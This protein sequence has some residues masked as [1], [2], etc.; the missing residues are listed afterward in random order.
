MSMAPSADPG[1]QFLRHS[2]ATVAY[3]GGKVLRGAP[4][5]FA[6]FQSANNARTPAK[7]LA[8]M[9][10]LFDWAHSIVSGQAA[11]HDSAPLPWGA[12]VDRFFAALKKF[13]DY[14]VSEAPLH[15]PVEKLLQGPVAD[16]L[17]HIGQLAILRRL[18]GSPVKGENYFVANIAAGRVGPEQSAPRR[19]F[20]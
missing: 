20:D 3:R 14:L 7:I 19:E 5:T 1:R 15:A 9:C 18:A 4:A 2:V 6:G 16:C 12:E 8:H 11:W 13:D 10:D 17:T